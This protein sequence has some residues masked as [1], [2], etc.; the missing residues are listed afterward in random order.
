MVSCILG[1][2]SKD[3]S[4]AQNVSLGL[5]VQRDWWFSGHLNLG[6]TALH[7]L[8]LKSDSA[9]WHD[10]GSEH[11]SD[12]IVLKFSHV[13]LAWDIFFFPTLYLHHIAKCRKYYKHNVCGVQ[14]LSHIWIFETPWMPDSSVLGISRAGTLEWL[15][16]SSSRGSPRPRDWTHISCVCCIDRRILYR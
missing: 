8:L 7:I 14:S 1:S 11:K 2:F 4:F 13:Y 12:L 16:I 10:K 3:I 6:H 9:H 15:A 5:S